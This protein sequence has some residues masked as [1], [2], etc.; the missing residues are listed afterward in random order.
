MNAIKFAGILTLT[1]V[2]IPANV[3]SV[4]YQEVVSVEYKVKAAFLFNFSQFIEWPEI[5]FTE[6]HSPFAIGILG[7]K[8]P[9]GTYL[10]EIVSGEQIAGHPLVVRHFHKLEEITACNILFVSITNATQLK[11]ILE[12]LKDRSILTVGEHPSFIRYGGIVRLFV[13]EGRLRV[14]I[15][16]S[17]AKSSGLNISS[18]LLRVADIVEP[19][20]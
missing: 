14:Q 12:S 15:N 19:K 3:F 17:A 4:S 1:T 13:D 8:N 7:E 18:K 9:F 6:V 2:I 11:T 20:G 10:D 5:G 16:P